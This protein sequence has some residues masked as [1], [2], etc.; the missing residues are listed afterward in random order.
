MTLTA[1]EIM[2]TRFHTLRPDTPVNE[3]VLR[4]EQATKE[5]KRRVFGMMVI[6]ENGNLAGMISMYDILLFMRPK[7]THI[8]G[9]MEDI[10]ITGL[11][12]HRIGRKTQTVFGVDALGHC[13]PIPLRQCVHNTVCHGRG[14]TGMGATANEQSNRK[15]K[16][17]PSGTL[18]GHVSSILH[19][20]NITPKAR[21]VNTLVGGS[22]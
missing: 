17:D 14:I 21:A 19:K 9:V 10:D 4:F 20:G 15:E 5:E 3:A 18:W 8:W 22:V 16:T 13:R 1:A 11:V 7:H 2:T 6:G 12:H